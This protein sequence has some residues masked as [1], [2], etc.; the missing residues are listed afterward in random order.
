MRLQLGLVVVV[1][2]ALCGASP[3]RP[4]LL[5]SGRLPRLSY[6]NFDERL[7]KIG[8]TQD[9][10]DLPFAEEFPFKVEEYLQGYKVVRFPAAKWICTKEYRREL[11]DPFL[12]WK[13]KFNNDGLKATTRNPNIS[14]ANVMFNT[15]FRYI[16]GVNTESTTI[17]VTKPIIQKRLKVRAEPSPKGE[18][19]IH[20]MCFWAGTE[21]ANK[22]LP[23]VVE[24]NLDIVESEP[25]SA[26]VSR[27]S[28]YALADADWNKARDQL[29]DKV[30]S[31]GFLDQLEGPDGYYMSVAYDS[32]KKT[33]DRRN[34]V[35]IPIREGAP[36]ISKNKT[37][38]Q[39][40]VIRTEK[41][42]E[43]RTYGATTWVCAKEANYSPVVDPLR[44]WQRKFDDNPFSLLASPKWEKSVFN[45]LHT[46]VKSYLYG[47][48]SEVKRFP[49]LFPLLVF[50]EPKGPAHESTTVC[51]WLGDEYATKDPPTPTS[52]E[53]CNVF[54]LKKEPHTV[55][56]K[57]FD[58][59]ALTY[60]DFVKKLN[61]LQEEMTANGDTTSTTKWVQAIYDSFY[62]IDSRRNEVILEAV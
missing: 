27:F 31:D 55:Y 54:I 1:G 45:Q 57:M 30:R 39:S 49:E 38:L 22:K 20:E 28:G 42:Y 8:I 21:Y 5:S 23:G 59:Y 36:I 11:D 46:K 6:S 25:F 48:N 43:E 34:E 2:V 16:L 12:G 4:R 33:Q 51:A 13:E 26:F 18:E 32:P 61:A 17:P 52:Q 37:F 10:D 50:H 53:S 56:A 29:L 40:T 3:K 58:S 14:S 60:W 7:L 41:D 47:V 62:K 44:D 19:W 24:D 15:L 35:W 9:D